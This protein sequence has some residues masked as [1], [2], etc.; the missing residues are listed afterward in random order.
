MIYLFIHCAFI[1]KKNKFFSILLS[2]SPPKNQFLLPLG[3]KITLVEM[4]GAGVKNGPQFPHLSILDHNDVHLM[5]LLCEV[6]MGH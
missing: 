6:H 3:G 2:P 5:G 4:G 1:H